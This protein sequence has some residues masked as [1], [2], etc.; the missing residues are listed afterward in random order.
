MKA[1]K[2]EERNKVYREAKPRREDD[3]RKWL[4]YAVENGIRQIAAKYYPGKN[5]GVESGK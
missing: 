1:G 5:K 3:W 4:L 2:Q